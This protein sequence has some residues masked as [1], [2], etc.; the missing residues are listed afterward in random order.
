[1]TTTLRVFVAVGVLAAA[2]AAV[3]AFLF[4]YAKL[5]DIETA[6]AAPVTVANPTDEITVT[7]IADT[8]PRPDAPLHGSCTRE[9][10][11]TYYVSV[12]A[13]DHGTE[14]VVVFGRYS[15]DGASSIARRVGS[16]YD[17][18]AFGLNFGPASEECRHLDGWGS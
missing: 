17:D 4:L 9:P 8:G 13:F 12:D 18:G 15:A 10:D 3:V 14:H 11:D 7:N 16:Y 2:A 6:I 5:G 1:M